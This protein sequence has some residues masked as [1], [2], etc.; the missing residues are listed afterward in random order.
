[1]SSPLTGSGT[2]S[3]AATMAG[4]VWNRSQSPSSANS[5]SSTVPQVWRCHDQSVAPEPNADSTMPSPY[6]SAHRAA[7]DAPSKTSIEN[8][9]LI[10]TVLERPLGGNPAFD[11][12]LAASCG[13]LTAGGTPVG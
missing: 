4:S 5:S 1:M 2:L 9:M 12:S 7:E 10:V 13:S 6:A 3:R 8:H 11:G